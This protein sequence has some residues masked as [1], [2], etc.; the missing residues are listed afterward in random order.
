[1]KAKQRNRP[2]EELDPVRCMEA[3]ELMR[4]A[5]SK[6][7]AAQAGNAANYV[8]RAIKSAEGARNHAQGMLDRQRTRVA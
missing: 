6:L 2:I 8:A 5:R 3:I 1:M 4:R 7:R